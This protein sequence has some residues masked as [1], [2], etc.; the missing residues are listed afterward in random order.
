MDFQARLEQF[1][2]HHPNRNGHGQNLCPTCRRA[3]DEAA[4]LYQADFLKGFILPDSSTFEE[5]QFFQAESLRQNLAE[6]LEQLTRHYTADGDF[7][8]AITYCRRWLAL[9]RLNEPAQRQLMLLYALNDQPAS[10]KRQF[11]ECVRLLDEE[12]HAQP[13]PETLQL[14]D[15]IQKKNFA[16]LQK[17]IPLPERTER[18]KESKPSSGLPEKKVY[19][20]PTYPSPFIGREKELEDISRL[21]QDPS[22]RLLTLLGPGGSGKTRLALQTAVLLS[23]NEKEYFPDGVC[24][25]SLAPLTDQESIV[26]ALIRGLNIASQAVRGVNTRERLMGYL[27]GRR[28]LLVLDNFEHLLGDES[29]GLISE[30]IGVAQQ[31]RLLV[32]SRERLNLLGEHIF[33]VEG[34]EMPGERTPLSKGGSGFRF[35]QRSAP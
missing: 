30:I 22:C 1:R 21:L 10:A 27:Q 24:F 17:A 23:Q 15:A 26:G 28:L 5:W 4:S 13:E 35:P 8:N 32:T 14:F 18:R 29:I 3:L 6:A 16:D 20:L 33:R 31:S 11:E 7:P 12:L 34:L 25:I 2:Q 9:D 19:S